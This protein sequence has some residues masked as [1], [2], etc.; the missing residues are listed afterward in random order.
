MS[1]VHLL[2]L[3]VTLTMYVYRTLVIATMLNFRSS[4]SIGLVLTCIPGNPNL[5]TTTIISNPALDLLYN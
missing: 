5:R 3:F 4:F 2:T 1:H